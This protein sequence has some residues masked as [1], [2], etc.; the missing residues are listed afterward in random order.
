MSNYVL[1]SSS[2]P[3]KR[4]VK[5]VCVCVYVLNNSGNFHLKLLCRFKDIAVFALQSFLLPH[6][7]VP[8]PI[9]GSGPPAHP[10]IWIL[11]PTQVHTLISSSISVGFTCMT[12]RQTMLLLHVHLAQVPSAVMWPNN[13]KN[14]SVA[15]GK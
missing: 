14:N 11:V 5:R 13:S 9:G 15:T 4:A 6:T 10:K 7:V 1:N 2:S 12:N 3:G 8:F